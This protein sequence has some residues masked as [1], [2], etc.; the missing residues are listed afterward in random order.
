MLTRRA[1]A[2]G[3]AVPAVFAGRAKSQTITGDEMTSIDKDGSAHITR[4]IA[5]PPSVSSEAK[6]MFRSDREFAPNGWTDESHALIKRAQ[7]VYP[8]KIEE[9]T[10]GGVKVKIITPQNASVDKND[11]VMINL[12]GGGFTSDSGSLLESIP[13]AGLSRT[14]VITVDYRLAPKSPFPAAVDDVV[15]VYK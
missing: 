4:V 7:S 12:H 1:L 9:K 10:M 2:S 11:R 5:I 14:R 15:A 6:E 8:A 3:F 13:I